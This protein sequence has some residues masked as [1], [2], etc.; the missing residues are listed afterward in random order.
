[1]SAGAI[2]KEVALYFTIV[3]K[4]T[5]PTTTYAQHPCNL[6]ILYVTRLHCPPAMFSNESSIAENKDVIL[7]AK[8][9]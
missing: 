8:N 1:M 4:Y 3:Q 7:I 9:S 6:L 5:A 2:E